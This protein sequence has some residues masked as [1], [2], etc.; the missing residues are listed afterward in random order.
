MSV[1]S[2]LHRL[3]AVNMPSVSIFN[4]GTCDERCTVFMWME[5]LKTV[6][7]WQSLTPTAT[8]R[9]HAFT[10]QQTYMKQQ[11]SFLHFEDMNSSDMSQSA[12]FQNKWRTRHLAIEN[13][14]YTASY[15]TRECKTGNKCMS[16]LQHNASRNVQNS[17]NNLQGHA[18]S[19]AKINRAHTTIY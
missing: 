11:N 9:L 8:D 17:W 15:K 7:R 1:S 10:P 12:L 4:C 16:F 2:N 18:R 14:M 6:D 5:S 19:L 3:I 13:R